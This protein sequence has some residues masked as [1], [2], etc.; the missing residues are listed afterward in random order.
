M[1]SLA[2][3]QRSIPAMSEHDLN[4]VR[5]LESIVAE[6]PQVQLDASHTLHAGMYARTIKVE[7][8]ILVVGAYI[9]V[10]TVIIVQGK[11]IIYVGDTAVEL[12]GYNVIP[13]HKG[14]KQAL[15]AIDE[16]YVT[17]IFPTEALTVEEAEEEFTNE[18]HKLQTRM[19]SE[20]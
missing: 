17:M 14:R 8:G 11:S 16:C 10:D 9:Q 1:H 19:K 5:S 13:A 20:A 2:T 12:N 18:A 6:M 3:L 4:K 15:L 7:P